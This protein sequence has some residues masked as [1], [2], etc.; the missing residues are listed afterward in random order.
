M[1]GSSFLAD[2]DISPLTVEALRKEGWDIVRV[3]HF[4][5]ANAR[6]A[7]ILQLARRQGRVVVTQDLDFSALLALGGHDRPSLITLRLYASD[8]ETV[9]RRLLDVVPRVETELREGCAVTIE[10]ATF[11]IRRLPIRL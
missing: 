6:D 4:L 7:D 1:A 3:S 9:T 11:R 2:M 5:S 10:D 8:P